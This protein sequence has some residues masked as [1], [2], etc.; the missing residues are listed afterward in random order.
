MV[1]VELSVWEGGVNDQLSFTA[2]L[3]SNELLMLLLGQCHGVQRGYWTCL[4]CHWFS[5]SYCH[6]FELACAC[7][8]SH[9]H[10]PLHSHIHT[11]NTQSVI[12]RKESL[13]ISSIPRFM[14]KRV[15]QDSLICMCM[16]VSV[17]ECEADRVYYPVLPLLCNPIQRLWMHQALLCGTED[18][19]GCISQTRISFK[20]TAKLKS[21]EGLHQGWV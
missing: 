5:H 19:F 6:V 10:W 1:T 4:L 9:T 8:S 21:S 11:V 20:I 16:C 3:L 2:Q 15:W 18:L 12:A 14:I 13:I 17:S 7:I